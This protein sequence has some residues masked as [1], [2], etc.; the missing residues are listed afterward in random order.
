MVIISHKPLLYFHIICVEHKQTFAEIGGYLVELK[1]YAWWVHEVKMKKAVVL[2][3]LT[4]KYNN[5]FKRFK[6]YCDIIM[7]FL[8]REPPEAIHSE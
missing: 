6:V 5:Y 1:W 3:F 2:P 7:L 4:L 8:C